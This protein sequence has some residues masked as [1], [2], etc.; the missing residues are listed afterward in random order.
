MP[1]T[2]GGWLV[3][4]RGWS[5]ASGEAAE[6]ATGTALTD[7]GL[8]DGSPVAD[9]KDVSAGPAAGSVDAPEWPPRRGNDGSRRPRRATVGSVTAPE[10]SVALPGSFSDALS[11]TVWAALASCC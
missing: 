11:F 10:P 8:A 3:A 1:W 4:Y 6:G 2:A 7:T 9:P 5:G